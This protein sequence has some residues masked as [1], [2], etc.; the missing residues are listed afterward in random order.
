MITVYHQQRAHEFARL[1]EPGYDKRPAPWPAH[2]EAVALVESDDLEEA[3]CLTNHVDEAWTDG[4]ED[5][6]VARS[7]RERSSMVGD[8]FEV[9]DRFYVVTGCG[10]EPLEVA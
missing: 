9:S 4:P 1:W 10:F 8:I 7:D 2:Y 3:W 5:L 6:V